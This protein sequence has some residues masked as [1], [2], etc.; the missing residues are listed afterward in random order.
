MKH[1]YTYYIFIVA[2]IAVTPL[3]ALAFTY[4]RGSLKAAAAAVA[5]NILRVKS[6]SG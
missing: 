4:S 6:Y 3:C 1:I 5:A 2:F